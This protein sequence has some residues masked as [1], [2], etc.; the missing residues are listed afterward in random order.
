[1]HY[2]LL[3]IHKTTHIYT[4]MHQNTTLHRR[5]RTDLHTYNR[6]EHTRGQVQSIRMNMRTEQPE[7][8]TK[9]IH[10]CTHQRTRT[11]IDE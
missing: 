7:I 6:E 2:E 10:L 8:Y 11:H 1:M 4:N 5:A 3:S 9:T